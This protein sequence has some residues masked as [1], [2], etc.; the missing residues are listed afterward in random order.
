MKESKYKEEKIKEEIVFQGKMLRVDRDTVRL[1]NGNQATREVVRH[2]GA[3]AVVALQ[4][5]QVLLVRQYRYPIEQETLEIPAGKLDPGEDPINCA[6]R[7]LREETGHRGNMEKIG[8]YYTS[9][10]F[11]NEVMHLFLA[12]DLVWDP[13]TADED[14]LVD[15]ERIPWQEAVQMAVENRFDDAKT[16]LG[17]LLAN[18]LKGAEWC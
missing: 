5:R 18:S 16:I 8:T 11:T 10:G 1:P 17:I 12:R 13:L 7:E 15:V 4:N 2:P 3:V 9:A 14:E 6:L